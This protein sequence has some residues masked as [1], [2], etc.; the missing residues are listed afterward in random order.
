MSRPKK[1]VD[2]KKKNQMHFK[3]KHGSIKLPCKNTL[4]FKNKIEKIKICRNSL[5]VKYTQNWDFQL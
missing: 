4:P 5:I 3:I 2:L 1:E